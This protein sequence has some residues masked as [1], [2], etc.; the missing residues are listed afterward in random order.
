MLTKVKYLNLLNK[1]WLNN[2]SINRCFS[3]QIIKPNEKQKESDI[4]VEN[5]ETTNELEKKMS[6]SEIL[7]Q[8]IKSPVQ[9]DSYWEMNLDD[10]QYKKAKWL[11]H[12]GGIS[13]DAF[14]VLHRKYDISIPGFKRRLKFYINFREEYNQRYIRRRH[15]ILG[16][17]LIYIKL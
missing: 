13:V 11:D 10:K 15:A 2:V 7:S 9:M 3:S 8:I 17:N 14:N 6:E 1:F 12:L 5:K 16:L 4:S